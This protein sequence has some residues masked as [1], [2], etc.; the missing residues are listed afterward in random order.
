MSPLV[1]LQVTAGELMTLLHVPVEIF[2]YVPPRE[3][4]RLTTYD[5]VPEVTATGDQL[6]V[7]MEPLTEALKPVGEGGGITT[8]ASLELG[9]EPAVV[10][11]TTI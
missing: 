1:S 9:E 5:T 8:L 4:A 11:A 3:V 6:N 2:V 10:E 7:M